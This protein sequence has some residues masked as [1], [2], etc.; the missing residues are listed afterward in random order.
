MEDKVVIGLLEAHSLQ[1]HDFMNVLQIIKGYLQLGKPDK[2]QEY[3]T[4]VVQ[5][6]Q[7]CSRFA[8]LE[9]P[10]LQG[11]L[12][13][14]YMM[15]LDK[16]K[17]LNFYLED[18]L[19]DWKVY[20]KEITR[21]LIELLDVLKEYFN[22]SI[23]QYCLYIR[24]KKEDRVELHIKGNVMEVIPTIKQLLKKI[25]L[26]ERD[27]FLIIKEQSPQECSICIALNK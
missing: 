27:F 3:I 22:S 20:D 2:A 11:F 8:K 12:L 13:S 5:P 10:Y 25:N 9:L 6:L 19:K 16:T 26:Q 18:S 1:R 15:N 14:F 24:M 23:L 4:K 21:V 7:E 17:L